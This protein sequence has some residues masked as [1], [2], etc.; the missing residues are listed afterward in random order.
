MTKNTK[1]YY[2]GIQGH[3]LHCTR[4]SKW[5][6]TKVMFLTSVTRPRWDGSANMQFCG[7]LG[8]WTYTIIETAKRNSRNCADGT[9]MTK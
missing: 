6:S 8:I 1:K 2:V 9:P 4:T 3:K 5:S 7:K